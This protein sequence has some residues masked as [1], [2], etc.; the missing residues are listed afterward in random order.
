MTAASSGST[1]GPTARAGLATLEGD[2]PERIALLD[3]A[4]WITGRGTDLLRVD[5][6]DGRVLETV[7]IGG[8]GIDVVAAGGALWVPARSVAVDATG[9]P[10]LDALRRVVP[11][12]PP[13]V[14]A[15]SRG[16]TDVH[17]LLADDGWRLARRHDQRL[18]LP[19]HESLVALRRSATQWASARVPAALPASMPTCDRVWW[20]N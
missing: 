10:T 4:L 9:L 1:R 3:G 19:V 16:R 13:N 15:R 17:G 6:T 11:A 8:G 5:P 2:A 14:V 20:E 7:E 18:R 12:A